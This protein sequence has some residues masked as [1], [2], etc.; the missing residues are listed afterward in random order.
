MHTHRTCVN[1]L[2]GIRQTLSTC[3]DH[4]FDE[5][6]FTNTQT[7]SLK[8]SIAQKPNINIESPNYTVSVPFTRH[9]N[10]FPHNYPPS[11]SEIHSQHITI[12]CSLEARIS[13]L[14]IHTICYRNVQHKVL[15][16]GYISR[17]AVMQPHKRRARQCNFPN[18][19]PNKFAGRGSPKIG[20]RWYVWEPNNNKKRTDG[21][22]QLVVFEPDIIKRNSIIV[23]GGILW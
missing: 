15:Y 23:V 17:K 18:G 11:N 3:Y 16:T 19:T 6:L 5:C 10:I 12:W 7:H 1:N 4:L 2:E 20:L 14:E 21:G 9:I 8:F 22:N 13:L